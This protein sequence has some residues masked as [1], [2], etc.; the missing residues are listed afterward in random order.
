MQRKIF[1]NLAVITAAAVLIVVLLSSLSRGNVAEMIVTLLQRAFNMDRYN[2]IMFYHQTIRNNMEFILFAAV[3]VFFVILSRFLLTRFAK[4]FAEIN[5][6]LDVLS[7]K[8]S[9]DIE[10]SNEMAAMERKLKAIKQTLDERE[11][12]ARSA[13]RRKNELVM[14]LAHDIKTPLTSV[15]G[16]LS[17]LNEAPEMPRE[18]NAKYIGITL[19]KANRLERYVDEF[20]EIAR[21]SFQA[22]MKLK[23]QIDLC[24]MLA[25]MAEEFRPL[26][27][28]EGKRIVLQTPED[29]KILCDPEKIA[30]VFNN[31]LKNAAAYSPAGSA[32]EITAAESNG[33]ASFN[34]ANEGSIPKDKL[35]SI[36]EK[37]YRLDSARSADTGGAGLGLAIAKEIVVSHGGRIFAES[38]GGNTVFTIELPAETAAR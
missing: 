22:E 37:F 33:V 10:L 16:Y 9:G 19:D 3:A 35:A 20:F 5:D 17:L 34:F 15:I 11:S 13:E 30:R 8:K 24:Y 27:E 38:E 31:V 26:L 18:Q 32:I 12:E 36:F 7:G 21:Y 1:I 4:Y 25:Q 23:E 14:Y 28:A 2:A 6:G 29:L